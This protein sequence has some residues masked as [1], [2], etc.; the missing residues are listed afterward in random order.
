MTIVLI[1]PNPLCQ[2]TLGAKDEMA[3]K[4]ARCSGCGTP[5]MIPSPVSITEGS[6][7]LTHP[8]EIPPVG[9]DL[10]LLEGLEPGPVWAPV[11]DPDQ[12]TPARTSRRTD[13]KVPDESRTPARTLAGYAIVIGLIYSVE[14]LYRLAWEEAEAGAMDF[15]K[16]LVG[17]LWLGSGY[18]VWRGSVAAIRLVLALSYLYLA[19]LGWVVFR[20]AELHRVDSILWLGVLISLVMIYTAYEALGIAKQ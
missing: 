17:T 19:G 3:G 13:G 10:P 5:F 8:E 18:C 15:V 14:A 1:C 6:T 7:Q 2:K 20:G 12:P 9:D 11:G 4:Y 16:L